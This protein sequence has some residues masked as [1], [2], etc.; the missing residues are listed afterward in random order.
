MDIKNVDKHIF[1]DLVKRWV[2]DTLHRTVQDTVPE[3]CPWQSISMAFSTTLECFK[4]TSPEKVEEELRKYLALAYWQMSDEQ[5]TAL[6]TAKLEDETSIFRLGYYP[7]IEKIKEHWKW[8]TYCLLHP[9]N[10]FT[11]GREFRQPPDPCVVRLPLDFV[12]LQMLS[13]KYQVRI[14]IF[15]YSDEIRFTPGGVADRDDWP[16]VHLVHHHGLWAAVRGPRE[17]RGR[18]LET[19]LVELDNLPDAFQHFTRRAVCLAGYNEDERCYR[20]LAGQQVLQIDRLSISRVIQSD[21]PGAGPS[22]WKTRYGG[23]S[24]APSLAGIP[25]RA[26]EFQLL[27]EYV[28]EELTDR[29][30]RMRSMKKGEAYTG[31]DTYGT[32][33]TMLTEYKSLTAG[34]LARCKARAHA[35]PCHPAPP[36]QTTWPTSCNPS[37]R[38][39]C[40]EHLGSV[41][42]RLEQMAYNEEWIYVLCPDN[43]SDTD[44][45]MLSVSR[46]HYIAV[47]PRMKVHTVGYPTHFLLGQRLVDPKSAPQRGRT[48]LVP[49]GKGW[50]HTDV[51]CVWENQQSPMLVPFG[52]EQVCVQKG[53][54]EFSFTFNERR[55]RIGCQVRATMHMTKNKERRTF[56]LNTGEHPMEPFLMVHNDSPS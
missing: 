45:N 44:P 17:A 41:I 51:L 29:L 47:H 31:I 21:D 10:Y 46:G 13:N 37:Q 52:H 1:F 28:R 8:Y 9:S 24:T 50:V 53:S 11:Q 6:Y 22:S 7:N 42:Q 4:N 35:A 49:N 27:L 2:S 33:L 15:R 19:S 32:Y 56:T 20:A 54:K 43:I 18:V 12:D 26:F 3:G 14:N 39:L 48:Q 16:R 40:R 34:A 25:D 36:P 38:N 55:E 30:R 5:K 23:S